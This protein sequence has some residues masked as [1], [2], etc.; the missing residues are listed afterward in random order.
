MKFPA[1]FNPTARSAGLQ[2]AVSQVCSLRA[3][4]THPA[5]VAF[6][7]PAGCKPAIRQI[8]NLRHGPV[9]VRP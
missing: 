6:D 9:P 3:P 8:E 5:F 4:P 7:A 2:P 1:T